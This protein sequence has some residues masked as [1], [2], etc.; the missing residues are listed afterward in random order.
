MPIH[1]SEF[2]GLHIYGVLYQCFERWAEHRQI[3]FAELKKLLS[4][5]AVQ[6]QLELLTTIAIK[7]RI[8]VDNNI[9]NSHARFVSWY[10]SNSVSM[11][12]ALLGA[13]SRIRLWSTVLVVP[14]PTTSIISTAQV[15]RNEG[16]A[17]ILKNRHQPSR[18]IRWRFSILDIPVMMRD[19]FST[20]E[21][22]V[23][24]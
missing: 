16:R 13:C 5:L 6:K 9:T 11:V 12:A 21:G 15:P 2:F 17:L 18:F 14:T 22:N 20:E 4:I 1:C 19:A 24:Y 7:G 8:R 23:P 10:M 3:D